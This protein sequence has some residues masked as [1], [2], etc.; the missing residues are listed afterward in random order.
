MKLQKNGILLE[1][2]Q[3]V[4]H[5]IIARR[6]KKCVVDIEAERRPPEIAKV[7]AWSLLTF[8]R[9]S[10]AR[11]AYPRVVDHASEVV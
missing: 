4:A 6:R 10:S 11:I 1:V 3:E 7:A 8:K 9:L 2:E 5:R